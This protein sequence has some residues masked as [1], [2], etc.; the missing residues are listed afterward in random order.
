MP[1]PRRAQ[2]IT[3]QTLI[4]E[5]NIVLPETSPQPHVLVDVAAVP[6]YGTFDPSK[7]SSESNLAGERSSKERLPRTL[8]HSS[9]HSSQRS[10]ISEQSEHQP[11]MPS[12]QPPPEAEN[13]LGKVSQDIMPFAGTMSFIRRRFVRSRST[14]NQIPSNNVGISVSHH[15]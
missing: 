14:D 3:T 1:S 6:E 2:Q 4:Q 11:L 9:S 12:S 5:A 15:H 10:A 13:I 7:L 8:R